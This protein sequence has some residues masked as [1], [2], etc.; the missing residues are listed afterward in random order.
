MD[1]RDSYHGTYFQRGLRHAKNGRPVFSV[2]GQCREDMREYGK[3][4]PSA[5]G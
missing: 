5:W 3:K 1:W 4:K 2:R